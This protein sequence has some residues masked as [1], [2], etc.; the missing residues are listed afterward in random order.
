M[1]LLI[2]CLIMPCRAEVVHFQQFRECAIGVGGENEDW[3]PAM[4]AAEGSGRT[5]LVGAGTHFLRQILLLAPDERPDLI[6]L[7]PFAGQ[8]PQHFILVRRTSAAKLN[9]Q[10]DHGIL[11]RPSYADGGADG[12]SLNQAAD[13]SGAT[14]W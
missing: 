1:L 2:L 7:N 14:F 5:V 8:V 13:Y 9:Q 6:A 3:A 11:C 4:Q 10:L 12:V